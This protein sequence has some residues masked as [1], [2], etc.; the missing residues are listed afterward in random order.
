MI[1][2]WWGCTCWCSPISG[3]WFRDW[4]SNA[5]RAGSGSTLMP[6]VVLAC[7]LALLGVMYGGRG[8][9]GPDDDIF[10]KILLFIKVLCGC[11]CSPTSHTDGAIHK[12]LPEQGDVVIPYI[13]ASVTVFALGFIIRAHWTPPVFFRYSD[14]DQTI[15]V[16]EIVAGFPGFGGLLST[17]LRDLYGPRR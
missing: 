1:G 16:L 7:L 9:G 15:I 12:P 4:W 13:I 3:D 14:F 5:R 8:T 2:R 17:S 6:F 10:L 11:G